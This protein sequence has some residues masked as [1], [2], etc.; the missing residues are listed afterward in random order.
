MASNSVNVPQ[1]IHFGV[2]VCHPPANEVVRGDG[3][4]AATD[5]LVNTAT[6]LTIRI[7]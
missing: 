1:Q 2:S 7:R 4:N 5:S 6:K 3:T